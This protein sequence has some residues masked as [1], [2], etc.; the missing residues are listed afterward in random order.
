MKW[1]IA[2]D[3]MYTGVIGRLISHTNITQS[4]EW[5]IT[6]KKEE[7][8]E[9]KYNSMNSDKGLFNDYGGWWW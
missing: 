5:I 7:E 1:W 9:K 3:N 8:I 4:L 6:Q 2:I